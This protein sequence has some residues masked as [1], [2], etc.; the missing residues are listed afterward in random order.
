MTVRYEETKLKL[1]Q[2]ELQKHKSRLLQMKDRLMAADYQQDQVMAFEARIGTNS[3]DWILDV[4]GFDHWAS[5][6]TTG[7]HILYVHGMPGAG[8]STDCSLSLKRAQCTTLTSLR[9]NN[10]YLVHCCE[11]VGSERS[12]HQ[13]RLQHV[14]GI[15]LLQAQTV[16]KG[17]TSRPSPSSYRTNRVSGSCPVRS[18]V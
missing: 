5:N 7:H 15:F 14:G 6:L 4:P 3:G 16:Q 1:Q 11:A 8:K 2:D 9:E 18:T 12:Q 13:S 17:D 10:T